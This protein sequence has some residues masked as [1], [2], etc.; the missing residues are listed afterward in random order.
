MGTV[1]S[2]RFLIIIFFLLSIIFSSL[3]SQNKSY[4]L[5]LVEDIVLNNA[6][7]GTDFWVAI[8]QNEALN[9][10]LKKRGVEIVVT[11]PY[12]T[13][14]TLEIPDLGIS[15]TKKVEAFKLTSFSSEDNEVTYALEVT[16]SETVTR[17]GIHLFADKPFAV[18]IINSKQYSAEGFQ[19]LPMSRWG[20]EYFHCSYYDFHDQRKSRGGGFII[21]ASETGTRV[22]INLHGVGA[23]QTVKGK[24][25]GQ[26]ITAT[27]NA[28][29]TFMVR[30]DGETTGQFDISGTEIT[31]SKPIGVISFHMRTMI[32]SICPEDR[33]NLMEM[34]TPTN[35]WGTSFNTVQLD[36]HPTGSRKG[37]GDLF[38]IVNKEAHTT[39]NCEF[40]D[41]ASYLKVGNRTLPMNQAAMF[42]ELDPI[43]DINNSNEK[44]SVYGMANWSSDKPV[45]L[46]QNA[47]SNRWDGDRKYS[48]M[49]ILV[50]PV[51]QYIRSAVFCT[52][53]NTGFQE[54]QLTLI[55]L[56]NHD[57]PENTPI[58][59]I[60]FDG[61]EIWR[62]V[63]GILQNRI[64]NTNY[65]WV[66]M[67]VTTGAHYLQSNTKI[68]AYLVGFDAYNAYGYPIAQGF[69]IINN[70]DTVPPKVTY[71]ENCGNYELEATEVTIGQPSDNPKQTDA[72]ISEIL[73][74][75]NSF[76]YELVI[77]KPETFK[78][79]NKITVR[80]FFLNLINNK[81]SGKAVYAVMDRAGNI[82]LD[83]VS[84][85]PPS[86]E[87]SPS[88]VDFGKVLLNHS[89]SDSFCIKNESNNDYSINS[90]SNNNEKFKLIDVPVLPLVLH[91]GDSVI[92][93]IVY[94]AGSEPQE[95]SDMDT[96]LIQSTCLDVDVFLEAGNIWPAISVT[97]SF[98]FGRIEKGQKVCLE[99]INT[100]GFEISNTGTA[101]LIVNRL[102]G[103]KIPFMLTSPT[104]PALPLTLHTGETTTLKSI[105]FIPQ[106][107]GKFTNTITVKSNAFEG[108]SIFVLSGSGYLKPNPVEEE[109][110][111]PM[112][113]V[114][115]NPATEEL[116]IKWNYNSLGQGHVEI[117]NMVGLMLDRINLNRNKGEMIYAVGKLNPGIYLIRLTVGAT[118]VNKKI[119]ILK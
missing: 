87:T 110:D 4:N 20:K 97:K 93:K 105:C 94:T 23:G 43:I 39:I 89:K 11:S 40:Y 37:K 104:V 83:S 118:A 119:V 70:L 50:P 24:K 52:P 80:K 73:L 6:S 7:L 102:D 75:E 21:I 116:N 115:P 68:Y 58:R 106:D 45:Q 49:S 51:N 109:R 57:D 1:M 95:S 41:I 117:I 67:N 103:F 69:N 34:L 84:Y 92:I 22:T 56:G 54:H 32:P 9:G 79:Q 5:P 62:L 47:F 99:E 81:E 88:N 17:K 82:F 66:R 74:F 53:L 44:T 96:V 91:N 77:D 12:T 59:S 10:V 71:K 3:F 72:G 63:P 26:T 38:R 30:G 108:D 2:K 36:R 86:I 55:A 33:D 98:D 48:P 8:P 64:P 100:T 78:P 31:S 14:V 76:N 13:M 46:I 61:K 60:K 19:A 15:K 27:L 29:S 90:I 35:M 113:T 111:T 42:G 16:E 112:L 107:S 85:D 18:W 65:Y 101:D 25:I 114:T 28:G